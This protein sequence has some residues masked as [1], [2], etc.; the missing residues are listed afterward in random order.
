MKPISFQN[1]TYSQMNFEQV[2]SHITSFMKDD[3]LGNYKLMLGTD[4]QIHTDHTRFITGIVIHRVGK[5][6]WACFHKEIIPRKMRVLHE[7]ISY[8]TTLTEEVASLFTKDKMDQ[9]IEIILPNIYQNASFT[10]EGH[11]DIG[12]GER[13]KTRAYVNEMVGRIESLGFEPKIKPHSITASGYANKYT[14]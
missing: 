6:A 7:R 8:E 5:G 4:S 10:V 12:S 13:N 1:I 2:F 14:K 9:L 11:I 3:P